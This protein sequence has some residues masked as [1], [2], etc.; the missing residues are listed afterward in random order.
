MTNGMNGANDSIREQEKHII[1]ML[2]QSKK[3]FSEWSSDC[4]QALDYYR[5]REGGTYDDEEV[6]R[7]DKSG[8]KIMQDI[9]TI[10]QAKHFMYEKTRSNMLD[11]LGYLYNDNYSYPCKRMYDENSEIIGVDFS[12]V[13]EFLEKN[14]VD[15]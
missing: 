13:R 9:P 11:T 2:E 7:I 10:K 1:L 8:R 3:F 4:D 15:I 6:K 14:G 12:I 5:L